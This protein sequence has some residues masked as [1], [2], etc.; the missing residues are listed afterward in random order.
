MQFSAWENSPGE[1]FGADAARP[2]AKVDEAFIR[3]ALEH[4]N[5]NVLRIALYQ[6]T[7]D[8]QLATMTVIK[9][10]RPG[11]PFLFSVLSPA[12]D[13]LVRQKAIAYLI[14][15]PASTVT[16]PSRAEAARLMELFTGDTLR[17]S[18]YDFGWEELAF[19]G[20][21]RAARWT[22]APPLSVIADYSVTIIGAGFSGL[23]A[24]IQLENL[25][26][27]YR[28]VERQAGLGGTWFLNDYPDAR[29]DITSFLY[30]FKF[31]KSYPWKSYFATQDELRD[32]VDYIVDKYR[33][34][35]KI[36]LNTKVT[37]AEWSVA[38]AKWVLQIENPDG[39]SETLHSNFVISASGLFSTPKLPDIPGIADFK[40][41]MFHSTGWDHSYDYS[42]KRVAVVGTGSTGSQLVRGV[43]EKAGSLVIYQR[44]PNWITGIPGY[45]NKVEPEK[46]W[47]LDHMPG[48]A[49]WDGYSHHVSQLQMQAFHRIDR[50][51]QAKGGLINEKNDQLR[52]GLTSF[53]RKQ[54]GDRDDLFEKLVPDFAPISRR[55]VV[56]NGFY[57]TLVR[58]NVTLETSGIDHFTPDGI[59]DNEGNERAFDLVVLCAGFKVSQYLWPV[60]YVGRDGMRLQDNWAEDGA[61][62]HITMT[63][64]GFPNFFMLY[65]PNAGVRAGSFHTW[66]EIFSRYI[67]NVIAQVI[68]SESSTVEVTRQAYQSYNDRL[69][70]EMREMLWEE[71]KGGGNSYYVNE[72]GRSG[73]NMPWTLQDFYEMVRAPDFVDFELAKAP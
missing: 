10:A 12:D 11:S 4:A 8:Q 64:P 39:T 16:T 21:P 73:V 54:V 52:E 68:E 18:E 51:W 20:F 15:N 3:R 57:K 69:D 9:H 55:L 48:Y 35:D 53:I 72:F 19:D 24:A 5:L 70:A 2:P 6:H 71:E 13:E 45:R 37:H 65:G 46:R 59:V 58:P 47:L 1:K 26:I 23:I 32:Y 7:G 56:D 30:Q 33:L 41:A 31:E 43:A 29:V 34:R 22:S 61:R 40:G 42:G 60:D 66:V 17:P 63:M 67:C 25:G 44:T 28:I 62:A 36:S 38:E 49:Q 27:A 14:E 50:A